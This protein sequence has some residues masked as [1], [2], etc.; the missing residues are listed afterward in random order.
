MTTNN[1]KGGPLTQFIAEAMKDIRVE[2]TLFGYYYAEI[3]S[4]K[5]V[6]ASGY[7]FNGCI[8][9][10]Q[11]ILEEWLLFKLRDGDTDLPIY[12][13]LDLNEPFTDCTTRKG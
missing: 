11:E 6:W 7:T 9:E 3:P 12:G 13:D 10:L 8:S 1:W 2:K 4:C 5:G